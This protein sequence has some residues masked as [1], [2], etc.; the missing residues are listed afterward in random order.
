[1]YGGLDSNSKLSAELD[2]LNPAPNP[3]NPLQWTWSSP[4]IEAL[5]PQ[6]FHPMMFYLPGNQSVLILGGC[7]GYVQNLTSCGPLSKGYLIET[8]LQGSV[9]SSGTPTTVNP[10]SKGGAMPV[11]RLLPCN[12]LLPNG[13]ILVYGGVAIDSLASLSDTWLLSTTTWTWTQI[14]LKNAPTQ[15]RAGGTC[16]LVAPNVV[17]VVGG[18]DGGI[19]TMKQFTGIQIGFINTNT[20]GWSNSFDPHPQLSA[21][22]STGVIV[23]ISAGATVVIGLILFL[24]GLFYWRGRKRQLFDKPSRSHNPRHDSQSNFPLIPSPFEDGGRDTPDRLNSPSSPPSLNSGFLNS[25]SNRSL[26]LIII[27][28]S[29]PS[30]STDRIP[31]APTPQRAFRAS[32]LAV[33]QEAELPESDRLPQNEADI[34]Y[35]HYVRTLQHSKQYE[36]R[37]QS[38]LQRNPT[39]S[40]RHTTFHHEDDQ[41][42][43]YEPDM[44][45]GVINLRD[46]EFGEEFSTPSRPT[47]RRQDYGASNIP[48]NAS[49]IHSIESS[50]NHRRIP[51]KGDK[52]EYE[53]EEENDY[54]YVPGVGG[55]ITALKAAKEARAAAVAAKAVGSGQ[56]SSFHRPPLPLGVKAVGAHKTETKHGYS[57]VSST[58]IFLTESEVVVDN[59]RVRRV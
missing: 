54:D 21:G 6:L 49:Q 30:S 24:G 58:P 13:D 46:I 50:P 53:E 34:Q 45:T 16:Q 3:V 57:A 39:E 37:Q 19:T 28:L 36:K 23:G 18:Y 5:T 42:L 32:R 31:L 55:P 56:R 22:L 8:I 25:K 43:H 44:A 9:I 59:R 51:F 52:A 14:N 2:L 33:K 11:A 48:G 7:D 12:T 41:G 27:P 40:S 15:G 4:T 20:W 29:T 38:P 35:G 26:P 47:Y 10:T 1:M 17:M